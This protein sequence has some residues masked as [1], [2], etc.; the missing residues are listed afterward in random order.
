[1]NGRDWGPSS[2]SKCTSNQIKA[3][4]PRTRLLKDDQGNLGVVEKTGLM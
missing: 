1:M 3:G 4:L 2:C